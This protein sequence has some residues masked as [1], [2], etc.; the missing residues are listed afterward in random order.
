[1]VLDPQ[2]RRFLDELE[3]LGGPPPETLSPAEARAWHAAGATALGPP[4][5]VA[6]I[7]DRTVPGPAG[8][9]PIRIYLPE[10]TGPFPIF[11]YYHGGGWVLGNI[12]TH[13][14]LCCTLANA[15]RCAVL[16]VEYRLAPEHKYPAAVDDAYAATA[17]LFENARQIGGD[18]QRVAV[19]GDSAGGNLAAAVCLMARD[20]QTFQPVL[21]VLVYPITDYNVDATSYQENA[22]G[23]LL[24]RAS[25]KWFWECYL[26]DE[27]D[28][29]QPY[30]SPLRA[31]DFGDLPPALVITAEYDPLRDEGEAYAARLRDAGVPVTLT[32]YD[33]MIHAFIR[34][35]AIF[36]KAR[37]AMQQVADALKQVFAPG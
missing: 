11:V 24:T 19:G 2:A 13:D 20:R 36:D 4:E 23:Y 12:A 7:R 30:A 10:G 27:E 33:G 31:R 17:W 37:T 25:M 16:S 26:A 1:M 32:R 29:R 3:S 8:E 34:R 28:G 35:T 5:P 22:E 14:G 6:A 21:Q 18:P 15:A 9:I